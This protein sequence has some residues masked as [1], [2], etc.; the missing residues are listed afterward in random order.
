MYIMKRYNHVISGYYG[1]E[2]RDKF[3]SIH[4]TLHNYHQQYTNSFN[5]QYV[6]K[7]SIKYQHQHYKQH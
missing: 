5:K 7:S 1:N 4:K 6:S 2:D 3:E